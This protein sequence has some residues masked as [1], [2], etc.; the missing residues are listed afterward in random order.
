MVEFASPMSSVWAT[1]SFPIASPSGTLLYAPVKSLAELRYQGVVRQTH[2]L[3][4]G[5][6][7]LATILKYFYN[8][9]VSEQDIITKMVELG[10]KEKIEQEGF[11]LL[12]L[13]RF[14]Q[15]KGYVSQGFRITDVKKLE[16]LKV[17]AIALVN[18]RGYAHFVVVKGVRYGEVLVADP[19]FGNRTRPLE[20][21]SKEWNGVLLVVVSTVNKG[22][23]AFTKTGTV[24]GKPNQLYPIF[25]INSGL[26]R[27][28]PGI[29][30]F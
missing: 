6:A 16:N 21:F 13:K 20:E 23:M 14:S 22:S 26:G 12:E 27:I 7:A 24:R 4:C 28:Q 19:A 9:A 10:D 18:V 30:E 17:P 3:S 11:S 8:D 5:A 29:G 1:S 2:D 25:S 15:S